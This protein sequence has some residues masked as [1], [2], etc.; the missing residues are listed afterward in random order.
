MFRCHSS[1]LKGAYVQYSHFERAILFKAV[2]LIYCIY[3]PTEEGIKAALQN[4]DLAK[5]AEMAQKFLDKSKNV[6]VNIGITGES[7]SGKSTLVNALRGIKNRTE[8]A[9]PTGVNET[10]MEPTEY[11]HPKNNNI[12][13][14]DLPGIGT[15]NFTADEYI[16]KMEFEKYDFFIIVSN[17]RFRENDAKLAKEIQKM[18]KK[19]YFVRSK[20]DQNISSEKMEDPKTKEE[21]VLKEVKNYCTEELEKLGFKSPKV[22]LVS[23]F[24]LH[25][26]EFKDLWKTLNVELPKH[27]R[28]VLLLALPNI[29]LDVVQQKKQTLASSI[30]WL[31][32]TSAAVAAVPVPGLSCGVDVTIILGFAVHCVVSLG[33]TPNLLQKL[34]DV[35]GV[36]LEDLKAEIKSPL[37]GVEITKDLIIKF[38]ATS[39]S[40]ITEMAIEEGLRF[41][42]II[43]TLVAMSLSG[44]ATYSALTYIL[45]SLTED[46]Q[47]VFKRSVGLNTS[48]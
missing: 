7:G 17:D 14:W 35:S 33:L 15:V 22:F 3:R 6:R 9:A 47:R 39:A 29:S 34:S 23:G 26:Y 28:D 31:T 12:R 36:S 46:A 2:I 20:I 32:V 30:T 11:P 27:Q 45:N 41:I 13:I 8:G 18:K 43:G 42:P 40:V 24:R 1:V 19:F 10:T 5:A 25:L 44:V 37:A 21:K 4:S 38:L 48:V 16:K